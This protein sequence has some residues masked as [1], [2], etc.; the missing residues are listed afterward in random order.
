MILLIYHYSWIGYL[1]LW[2]HQ[3]LSQPSFIKP[4]GISATH[5]M[6]LRLD[7]QIPHPLSVVINCPAPR[8]TKFIKFPP[9]GTGKDIT[10][11]WGCSSVDWLVHYFRKNG[12]PLYRGFIIGQEI[13]FCVMHLSVSSPR[14]GVGILTFPNKKLSKSPLPGKKELSK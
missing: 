13:L 1:S 11:Q 9:S 14:G 12:E 7:D 10:A 4:D 2:I 6:K 5:N 3:G 8:K